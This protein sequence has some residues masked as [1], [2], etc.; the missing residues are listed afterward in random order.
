MANQNSSGLFR[1]LK[2]L[3]TV[4]GLENL[5]TSQVTNMSRMF[6]YCESLTKL[7]LGSWNT[8]NV[9]N[10]SWM[11]NECTNLIELNLDNWVL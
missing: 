8:S 3:Q 1:N 10:M 6:E 7:D 11:F 4:Q 5:D 2:H 9:E